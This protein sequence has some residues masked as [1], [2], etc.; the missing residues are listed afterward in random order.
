MYTP[1]S[2]KFVKRSK[3][4]IHNHI[5][6]TETLLEMISTIYII[7]SAFAQVLDILCITVIFTGITYPIVSH[8]VWSPDGWLLKL[9]YSDFSGT[10]AVHLLSGT[11]SF[12]AAL[13][14][15][16]RTGRFNNLAPNQYTGHSM[17][18]RKSYFVRYN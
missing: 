7:L 17:T 2:Q 11:C 9:G 1:I 15:E 3:F 13:F 6:P 14:V 12:V 10:G 18:V 5:T 8:W 4:I 16:P